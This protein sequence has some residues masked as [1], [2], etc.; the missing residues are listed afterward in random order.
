VKL[1]W[2][3]QNLTPWAEELVNAEYVKVMDPPEEN[4]FP[5]RKVIGRCFIG[6]DVENELWRKGEAGAEQYFALVRNK[7]ETR[8]WVH[9][10]EGVNE[11]HP[12]TE[13]EIRTFVQ[14]TKRWAE[15]MKQRNYKSVGLCLAEGWPEPEAAK[16]Y[17]GC[18]PYLDYVALH[19]YGAPQMQSGSPHHCLRYR[20][21]YQEWKSVADVVPPL[22]ITEC[23][24][25]GGAAS[26][27]QPRKGWKT[28]ASEEEYWQQLLWYNGELEKDDIVKAAFIFSSGPHPEWV[29]FDFN[30]S[31]SRRL[32]A[33]IE[34]SIPGPPGHDSHYVLMAQNVPNSWRRAL[35]HYFDAY[36]VTNGQS[37]DDAMVVHGTRHHI[38]LVGSPDSKYGIPQELEDHIRT[39]A[40]EIEID[41]M[42]A[43]NAEELKQV[44]DERVSSGRRFG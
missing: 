3:F 11:P 15:M 17:V 5:D 18:F 32:H 25:D 43:T 20:R 27:P 26:P 44:A 13:Q 33:A 31:L 4:P 19:E 8:P 38:T 37:H 1:S 41:R 16:Y 34:A 29:D 12:K 6:D 28:F 24:I 14:F 10:W 2:H 30:Q 40:P 39:H 9:A 23:G 21:T 22:L 35:E 36:K 42:V 7:Y